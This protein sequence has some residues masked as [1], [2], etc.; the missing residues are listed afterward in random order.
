M[1]LFRKILVFLCPLAIVLGL[2][3]LFVNKQ[4]LYWVIVTVTLLF[5]LTLKFLI[6]EKFFSR[7]FFFMSLLCLLSFY[8]SLGLLFLISSSIVRQVI[9]VAFFLLIVFYLDNLFLFYYRPQQYQPNTLEKIG[10]FINL[11]IFF[12]MAIN[13]NAFSVFLNLPM[14]ILLIVLILTATFL[15]YQNFWLYKIKDKFRII[16]TFISIVIFVEF[17]WAIFFLPTDF[18]INGIILTIIYYLLSGLMLAQLNKKLEKNLIL[19]YVIL[20]SAL[21]AFVLI[22]ANWI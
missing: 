22:T 2:E 13:L 9:V 1:L 3:L 6:K 5:L 4:L 17:F 19:R 20:S 7:D 10:A 14:W 15:L 18:Y 8:Y 12:L 21:S 11:L 16:Y